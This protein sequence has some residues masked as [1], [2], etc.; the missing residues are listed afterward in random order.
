[1]MLRP[2]HSFISKL[3]EK[4]IQILYVLEMMAL[5]RKLNSKQPFKTIILLYILE[6]EATTKLKL[7]NL[8]GVW[9]IWELPSP[10]VTHLAEVALTSLHAQLVQ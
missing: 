9:E 2:N 3:I 4:V 10:G 5:M 8:N 1:M 7:N 6:L